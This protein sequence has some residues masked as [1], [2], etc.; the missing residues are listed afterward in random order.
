[1]ERYTSAVEAQMRLYYSGL[2][3][4]QKRH[5]ASLESQKL[6]YGGQGYI[7]KLLKISAKT[8]H[9]GTKELSDISLYESIGKD[10]QRRIGGGRKRFFFEQVDIAKALRQ[11]IEAH[12]AGSPTD[13][14]VYWIHYRPCEIAQLFK[15]QK[16]YVVSN[17]MIK[18][19]L[20]EMGF[21][22][23][24]LSKNL[25]TGSYANRNKQFELI[26]QLVL[27]F[28][29]ECPIIAID[30]KKKECL[31]K[32]YRP[33]KCH[34]IG[35]VGSYDHDYSHLSEGIVIPHGVY[36]LKLNEGY[37]TIGTSHETAAFVAD[38]IAWWWQT[39]GKF[40]YP[41]ATMILVLCDSGGANNHRHYVF[42]K[43]MQQLVQRIGLDISICHY[44]P[45]SSKWNPI[46]HRL[47]A[48]MHRAMQGVLFSDYQIIKTL[49]DKT[50][51]TTGLK[52]HCRILQKNYPIG[53]K[54][55]KS[56][57]DFTKIIF[58]QQSSLFYSFIG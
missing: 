35:N 43:E 21:G 12:K 31:G 30:C 11:W 39:Y 48:P 44:P 40:N 18:R 50:T 37:V 22:Y 41:D 57:V 51:T 46:E 54:T 3:E 4:R 32:L 19:M 20:R 33:G 34:M 17:G 56:N 15:E 52:V 16:N 27:M 29:L 26:F 5:Y 45:Y 53:L 28:S 55:L 8:V 23:R 47:F 10:R 38:N 2:N 58:H 13:P 7:C 14:D 24:K 42:K 25:A 1:M 36:D 9:K 49:I 6:G